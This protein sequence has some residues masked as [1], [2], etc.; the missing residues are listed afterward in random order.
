[1]NNQSDSLNAT[2]LSA[3]ALV[4]Q[5][6]TIVSLVAQRG[7]R[8]AYF[9]LVMRFLIG[10]WRNMLVGAIGGVLLG[11]VLL[12]ILPTKWEAR[13]VVEPSP[14]SQ[15]LDQQGRI[16]NLVSGGVRSLLS[17][18]ALPQMTKDFLQLLKSNLVGDTLL[19]DPRV[20]AEV[21]P[22]AW[23]AQT[24]SFREPT[25]FRHSISV[26]VNSALGRPRWSAPGPEMMR[27][28]LDDHLTISPIGDGTL[29]ELTMQTDKAEWS[30]YL[31]GRILRI[32]DQYLREREARR[33]QAS[34]DY[35][36]RQ[37]NATVAQDVRTALI[38]N[39]NDAQRRLVFAGIDL[40]F[41]VDID[42]PVIVPKVP[43]GPRPPQ[44]LLGSI[45]AGILLSFLPR[46]M[47][48]VWR[49]VR[50]PRDSYEPAEAN[51]AAG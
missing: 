27:A 43:S 11:I 6:G 18:D 35:W 29:Q 24:K 30:A 33:S 2:P 48:A 25:T 3:S 20:A 32:S 4:L 44:I 21:F 13:T 15:S 49:S 34:I 9:A 45:V 5:D 36:Q 51:P 37:L 7:P 40:P 17:A 8:R 41:A 14:V 28:Y 16:S 19:K 39:I 31:L 1:M 47:R 38:S 12:W 26:I 22:T 10:S 50:G 42:D 46:L 23:D